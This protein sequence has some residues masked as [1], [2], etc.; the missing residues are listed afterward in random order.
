MI[1]AADPPGESTSI[2]A[3][4][5]AWA[6]GTRGLERLIG[7]PVLPAQLSVTLPHPVFA[8]SLADL[9]QG[10]APTPTGWRYLV[11]L[12]HQV[13]AQAAT[14]IVDGGHRFAGFGVG[15]PVAAT[16]AAAQV[17]DSLLGGSPERFTLAVDE[18]YE[19]HVT[20]LRVIGANGTD[21]GFIPVG[22]TGSLE[23]RLYPPAEIR[24]VLLEMAAALPDNPRPTT[25]NPIGG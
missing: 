16:G 9:R 25:G 5:L 6:T 2:V 14:D 18:V 10:A 21:E 1:V 24:S 20:L 11:E 15:P 8:L 19:L 12:D 17:A 4:E 3:D 23:E 22:R 7:Q 13:V